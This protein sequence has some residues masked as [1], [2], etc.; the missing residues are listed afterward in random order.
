MKWKIYRPDSVIVA[1][2]RLNHALP[3]RLCRLPLFARILRA[4]SIFL[5]QRNP[6][7]PKTHLPRREPSVLKTFNLVRQLGSIQTNYKGGPSDTIR[8]LQSRWNA[9]Q[10]CRRFSRNMMAKLPNNGWITSNEIRIL[11]TSLQ[12]GN[13]WRM[14]IRYTVTRTN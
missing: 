5:L 8:L 9:F 1:V 4:K 13:E 12:Y 10:H 2:I 6:T 3:K 11:T 14:P 7:Q